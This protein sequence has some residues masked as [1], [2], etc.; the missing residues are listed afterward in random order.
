MESNKKTNHS[1]KIQTGRTSE[2]DGID[3]LR[4]KRRAYNHPSLIPSGRYLGGL[5]PLVLI[6][7]EL[8]LKVLDHL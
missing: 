8:K 2:F 4:C 7:L 5:G 3:Q 1:S 6:E